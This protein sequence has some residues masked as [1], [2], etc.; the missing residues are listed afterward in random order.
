MA[1]KA[2]AG[3]PLVDE[4]QGVQVNAGCAV[5][6]CYPSN[7]CCFVCCIEF[8]DLF[9]DRDLSQSQL[10]AITLSQRTQ[11]D[12]TSWSEDVERERENLLQSV[13]VIRSESMCE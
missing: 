12:M 1:G 5:K 10:T 9:P 13:S 7:K 8:R 4:M 2:K 3:I 11:N 6:L